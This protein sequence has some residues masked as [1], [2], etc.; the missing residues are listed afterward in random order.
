MYNT[1]RGHNQTYTELNPFIYEQYVMRVTYFPRRGVPVEYAT[2]TPEIADEAAVRQSIRTDS[3]FIVGW[4]E[5]HW[6]TKL[7]WVYTQDGEFPREVHVTKTHIINKTLL[8]TILWQLQNDD[9]DRYVIR[10]F[11]KILI[12]AGWTY[13]KRPTG[14][15]SEG[16]PDEDLGYTVPPHIQEV[17]ADSKEFW[18]MNKMLEANGSNGLIAFPEGA[19]TIVVPEPEKP[20]TDELQL[21]VAQLSQQIAE[22]AK[23]LHVATDRTQDSEQRAVGPEQN[24]AAVIS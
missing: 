13:S 4:K 9:R 8:D 22:L 5:A 1:A 10:S 6:S 18:Y 14:W 21:K 11:E 23:A 12:D 16:Q 20:S 3:S 7:P 15:I 17:V 19:D 2:R 24:G